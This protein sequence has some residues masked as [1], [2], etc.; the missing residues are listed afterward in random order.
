MIIRQSPDTLERLI[1]HLDQQ[2]INHDLQ[3][4]T[5]G[6][7]RHPDRAPRDVDLGR[8]HAGTRD[9]TSQ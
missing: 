6:K 8:T 2:G 5:N 3:R 4:A 7:P 1:E 9:E